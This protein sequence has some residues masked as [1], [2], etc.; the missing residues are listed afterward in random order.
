M[1]RLDS[2]VGAGLLLMGCAATTG[3]TDETGD[4]QAGSIAAGGASPDANDESTGVGGF[5][6]GDDMDD[7]PDTCQYV[8][9]L[10][11]ID[12]SPSM[13]KHQ[14]DLAAAFPGF[15]AAMYANLPEKVSLHVGVTTTSF[16]QGDCAEAVI[17]CVTAASPQEVANHYIT[18]MNGDT[19]VNGEQGRLFEHDGKRY[20]EANTSDP[21]PTPL[22]SW[23]TGAATAAGETGCSFEMP[24]AGAG[25]AA[26]SANAQHNAGFLRDEDSVLL[27][28]VLSDEPDKSPEGAS[29]YRDM[30][31]DAKAGCGGD[32][33]ILTAGLVNQC[34]QGV[35]NELWQFLN[36][37][38]EPPIIGD[39]K[40]AG[41]YTQVVG[42]ALAQVVKQKC[43]EI[44]KLN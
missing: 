8:D 43:D 12:N 22:E 40:D 18:P 17:N 32:N 15:V 38:G 20:F 23:F 9:I 3:A 24:S 7:G 41:A 14:E 21:D 6:P 42:D 29:T 28:F 19:G 27:V 39:I 25:Y 13:G 33:C 11:V 37:F 30:L 34:I 31:V 10:F 5:A 35:N 16:F 36:A 4:G 1:R 44:G 26:H 2:M